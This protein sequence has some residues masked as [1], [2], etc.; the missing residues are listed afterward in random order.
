VLSPSTKAPT[1]PEM[2][3]EIHFFNLDEVAIQIPQAAA[4]LPERGHVRAVGLV[5]G[6]CYSF[7]LTLWPAKVGGMFVGDRPY[8]PRDPEEA[9][10]MKVF[11]E[12][13]HCLN[14]LREEK[15]RDDGLG[16]GSGHPGRSDRS[17]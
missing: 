15:G 6:R 12:A 1:K 4:E 3:P 9:F 8:D 17:G 2:P 14:R 11:T 7:S 10:A 16:T 13:V 5:R